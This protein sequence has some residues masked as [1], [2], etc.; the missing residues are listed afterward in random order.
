MNTLAI[1]I[2]NFTYNLIVSL[3]L[4]CLFIYKYIFFQCLGILKI[5]DYLKVTYFNVFLAFK[6]FK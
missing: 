2:L 6:E 1:E 4:M 5:T 3:S